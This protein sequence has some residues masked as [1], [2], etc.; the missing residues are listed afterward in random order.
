MLAYLK[1]GKGLKYILDKNSL[2][3]GDFVN[4]QRHGYGKLWKDSSIYEGQFFCDKKHGQGKIVLKDGDVYIG[5]FK[6][7]AIDGYGRYIWKNGKHEYKG[8]FLNGKFHG[9]GL[10]KWEEITNILKELIIKELKKEKEKLDIVM[11]ENVMLI[12]KMENRMEKEF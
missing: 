12:L 1:T 3:K 11:G 2:Y 8:Q 5:E 6:N 7:N 9:E 4:F 10:Y